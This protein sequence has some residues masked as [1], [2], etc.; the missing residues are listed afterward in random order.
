MTRGGEGGYRHGYLASC[1]QRAAK[2]G[3]VTMNM[4]AT[5]SGEMPV[6]VAVPAQRP[7]PCGCEEG[8]PAGKVIVTIEPLLPGTPQP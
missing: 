7:P 5:P 6:Y 4:M 3:V 8:S 1:P 2:D